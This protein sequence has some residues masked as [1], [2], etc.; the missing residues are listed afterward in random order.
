LTL[1]SV[2]IV[3]TAAVAS[4]GINIGITGAAASLELFVVLL[5]GRMSTLSPRCVKL[6]RRSS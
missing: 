6:A 3:A 5:S 2:V 4:A 1:K